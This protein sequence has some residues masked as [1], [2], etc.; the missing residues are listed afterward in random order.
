MFA[1]IECLLLMQQ[2]IRFDKIYGWEVTLLE[3]ADFWSRVPAQILPDFHFYNT[4]VSENVEDSNSILRIIK[5]V[6]RPEDFVSWKL[7]IDT[8]EVEI[9]IVLQLASDAAFSSLVDEFFFE[10]HFRCEILMYCGWK[11]LMPEEYL[12]LRLDR[13]H[14]M[15]LFAALR[16]KGIRAHVWP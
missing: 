15:D 3:P 1:S 11:N 14:A 5:Q 16:R 6:A 12:G 10:L 2:G 4:R 9:P 8:P 7:D 13:P